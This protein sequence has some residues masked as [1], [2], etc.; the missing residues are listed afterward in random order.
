MAHRVKETSPKLLRWCLQ[1]ECIDYSVHYEPGKH[2]GIPETY[3]RFILDFAFKNIRGY[4]LPD[5]LPSTILDPMLKLIVDP[6]AP[7]A[8]FDSLASAFV[9][10][11]S[12]VQDLTKADSDEDVPNN[13]VALVAIA[14]PN[15]D[16]FAKAQR[17]DAFFVDQ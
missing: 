17:K 13:L 6:Y 16:I 1:I 7:F 4:A 8:A 15:C 9:E 10:T 2:N 3:S 11:I 14:S 12:L 5:V